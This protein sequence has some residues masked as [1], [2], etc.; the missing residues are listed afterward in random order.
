[1]NKVY[2]GFSKSSGVYQIINKINGHVYFGQAA[3][4][5]TRA[6][7][8]E[9]SLNKNK[10]DNK[11]L[12]RAWNLYGSDAFEFTVLG[13]YPDK[14]ERDA[15]EQALITQFYGETCYNMSKTVFPAPGTWSL[16]PEETRAKISAATTG[17]KNGF[18][19]KNHTEE[20]REIM[21]AAR[22]NRK[23]K[24]HSPET[25]AK[26][27]AAAMGKSPSPETRAKLSAAAKKRYKQ[28]GIQQPP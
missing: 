11:H 20:T 25:K 2:N 16:T 6:K 8:H 12:Q 3:Q 7:Q 26:M 19:G 22:N 1:M 5:A 14:T 27:S 23:D 21:K 28:E 15:A 10:H 17:E 13:V 18:F 24:P 4:L 9:Y